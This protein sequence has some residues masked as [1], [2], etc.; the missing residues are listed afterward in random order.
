MAQRCQFSDETS[1]PSSMSLAA[2]NGPTSVSSKP[3]ELRS[4]AR[5]LY[6]LTFVSGGGRE[7]SCSCDVMCSRYIELF[8][9]A[10]E[11]V[12]CRHFEC[13]IFLSLARVS[14]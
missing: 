3:G 11:C 6:V 13:T 7:P 2:E 8:E 1:A 12:E 10:R 5:P 9:T 4:V 14:R